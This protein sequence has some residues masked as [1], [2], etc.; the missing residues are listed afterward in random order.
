MTKPNEK[1][2]EEQLAIANKK[3]EGYIYPDRAYE[4]GVMAALKWVLDE[5]NALPIEE[6]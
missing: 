4:Y 3:T 6:D 2:I 5:M 1:Q